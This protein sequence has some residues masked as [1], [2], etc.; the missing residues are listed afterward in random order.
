MDKL[1]KNFFSKYLFLRVVRTGDGGVK[2]KLYAKQQ[3]SR[4]IQIESICRQQNKIS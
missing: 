4:L 3:N 2:I 1:K